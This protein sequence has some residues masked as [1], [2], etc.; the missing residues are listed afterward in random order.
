MEPLARSAGLNHPGSDLAPLCGVAAAAWVVTL[1]LGLYLTS[2]TGNPQ[3][4]AGEVVFR[5]R[6]ARREGRAEE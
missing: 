1:A 3:T 6:A 4:D 5:L 2:A